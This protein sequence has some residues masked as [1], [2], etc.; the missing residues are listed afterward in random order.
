MKILNIVESAYRGTLEEQDDTILWLSR[1]LKNNGADLSVL[2]RGNAVNY[3]VNQNC[4]PLSLGKSGINHP[5]CPS[6]DVKKLR[7]KGVDVFVVEDDLAERGIAKNNCVGGVQMISA[8][9][10]AALMDK[11]D[12]IWHW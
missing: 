4:P 3:V 11:H 7:E 10:V 5:A 8:G 2:L 6:E 12:Q 1:A 9:E